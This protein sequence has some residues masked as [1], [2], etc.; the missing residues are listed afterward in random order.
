MMK[1]TFYT[2]GIAAT[3]GWLLET[4]TG[5][6]VVDAPYEMQGWLE[7]QGI[8]PVAIL[9]THQHFDHVQAVAAIAER[10]A[11]PVYAWQAFSR[12][13]TLERLAGRGEIALFHVPEFTVTQA[14][15]G[16]GKLSLLGLDWQLLHVPGHSL[17]SVCFYQ[18]ELGLLFGGDVLMAGGLGRCDF[19]GG[20]MQQLLSGIQQKLLPL[21]GE[22]RVL[23]GHGSETTIKEEKE[24]NP[25]LQQTRAYQLP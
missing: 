20:S 1:L 3:N 16:L 17:D 18:P 21:P 10:W 7:K 2:G 13:L 11:C 6:V 15:D 12:D 19:P 4:E 24:T 8:Q 22:T 14:L 5:A 23:P 9:V 25:Y